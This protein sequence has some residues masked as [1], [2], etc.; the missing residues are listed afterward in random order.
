MKIQLTKKIHGLVNGSTLEITT[1]QQIGGGGSRNLIVWSLL[2]AKK[3]WK[4]VQIK[5]PLALDIETKQGIMQAVEYAN[6]LLNIHGLQVTY[7][8]K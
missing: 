2:A 6:S 1:N 4:K 7:S 5:A 8:F 3:G